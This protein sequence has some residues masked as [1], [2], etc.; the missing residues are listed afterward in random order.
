MVEILA[1]QAP[2]WLVQFPALLKREQR[3][4]L[5]QEILGATRDRMLR[6]IR[7]ALDT[8][9]LEAPLLW[10]FEDLQWVDPSTVDLISASARKRVAAKAMVIITKRQVDMVA[11][12][13]PLKRLKQDLLVHHLCHEI[14]LAPL[15]EAEVAEYLGADSPGGSLPEGFAELI[16]RHSEG[17]PLFMIAA[18]EHMT[19]HGQISREKGDGASESRSSKSVS[20]CRRF[21][22]R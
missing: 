2:T 8:V 7:E 20:M 10:I 6:E 16:H 5:Q 14:M 19:E 9:N 17:N 13:H 18:L 1:A 12:E 22:V 11:P 15:G 21:C 3:E 4:M